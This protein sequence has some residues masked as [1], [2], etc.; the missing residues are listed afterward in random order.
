MYL[1]FDTET[2]GLPKDW[3]RPFTDVDNWPRMVQIAWQLHDDMG[4][5]LENVDYLIQPEGYDIPYDAE[6]VHGISTKLAAA[7]GVPVQQALDHLIQSLDKCRF[8]VGQNLKF[9][10]NIVGSELVRANISYEKLTKMPVLDT[11]TETT[12]EMLKIPGGRGGRFKL[13][14]LTELHKYLFDKPFAEAHNATADVE[15]TTRCFFE[16]LRRGTYGEK[17]LQAETGYL[18]RFREVNPDTIQP[19]GLKHQNLKEKS[20]ALQ[21]PVSEGPTKADIAE[22][23]GVL[24]DATFFH[25]HN[26][27]QYSVLQSTTEIPALVSKA[28]EFGMPAVAVTDLGNM[29]GA[30]H[31]I[32]AV[33]RHNSNEKK[34]VQEDPQYLPKPI[35]AMV[36][37]EL[38]LCKDRL[39]HKNKDNGYQIVFIAKNKA[40]YH[41]LARLSSSG[42]LEG[43]YYV[44]RIDRNVLLENKS[45]I[46]VTTGGIYGEVPQLIL[47]EGVGPAEEAFLWWKSQFGEDFYVELVRHGLPEEDRVNPVLLEFAQKHGVKVIAA[48]DAYYLEQKDANAHDALLCVKEGEKQSTPI[49]RGRGFRYGFP[50]DQFYFKS[51]DEMKR[52][53][54]DLPEAILNL[55]EVLDKVEEF[56]LAREVLL[57]NFEIPE[58]F[59]DPADEANGGKNGENAYLRHLT[60][61]GAKTRYPELTD[62][63]RERIDFELEIIAKTGYPG[64]FLIV[65]D[66]CHEARK[67][68]VSVG[69]GRG[70]AAGSVVAYCN[71]ITN[72]DPIKYD[73]LFERFLNPERV[74]L[75]DIDID[76]D[77][78]GRGK[79][80]KYVIDK[81]GENQ[82]AQIITYGKMAAKSAIRDTGRVMELPL[83]DTDHL[84]KMVPNNLS[85]AKLFSLTEKEL[86]DKVRSEEWDNALAL[87]NIIGGSSPESKVLQQ[88]LILEGSVRNTGIHACG[89]II[90][91]SDIRQLIPVAS[92]KDS[93]LWYTQFDNA[94][95]ESAGLLKMDFLGLRTL[96]IIKKAVEIVKDLTGETIDPEA[97]PLDDEKTYELFQRGETMGIFQYES[98][99]MRKSLRE[100]K[101]TVFEDLIAMNALYRPGPMDYIPS[102]IRRKHGEE[103]IHYD[104]PEME[105]ILRE[106]YGITVYQEQVMLLSQHLADFTKG[107]ADMLRKAMGKKLK[108]VLDTMKPKF[109]EQAH[110][111]GHPKEVLEKIWTDWEKFAAYAFNKSH[112]TCYAY[113]AFQTAYLKAHFPEAFYASVL[114]NN[115]KDIKTLGLYME[116]CKSVG[117]KV[118]VPSVNVSKL[119]FTVDKDKQIVFGLA[120]IKGV[121]EAAAK[122]II[123]EREANGPYEDV[124]DF[125]KRVDLRSVNKKNIENLVLSGGFDDFGIPRSA[126]FVEDN[127][128]RPFLDVLMKFGQALQSDQQNA[129]ASLFGEIEEVDIQYPTFPQV[130]EWDRMVLLNK[131]KEV[132]GLYISSHP[133]DDFTLEIGHFARHKIHMLN[134]NLNDLLPKMGEGDRQVSSQEFTFAGMIQGV[135]HRTSSRD[136][137]PFGIFHIMDHSGSYEFKLFGD[138]YVKY[139]NFLYE[140]SFVLFSIRVLS[141]YR[142]QD[143]SIGDPRIEFTRMEVLG[144]V[145]Q[146]SIKK[147]KLSLMLNRINEARVGNL[148]AALHEFPG[149]TPLEVEFREGKDR[150]SFSSGFKIAAER[151]LFMRLKEMESWLDWRLN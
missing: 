21:A 62:E 66:F 6:K 138:A 114:S 78:L 47:Q 69:P 94:V 93:E 3:N 125:I 137:K 144:E 96:S 130:P 10:V 27:S 17:A 148:H 102:F 113:V 140:A 128:G 53:F 14:T 13:P 116:A 124:F 135:Q 97:V 139:R 123:E 33:E 136:G 31:F 57:P 106:T 58:Q 75:P 15:A 101:P 143:G 90:T 120:G 109:I 35:R 49:G 55:Q 79:V 98:E 24:K 70:S 132:N 121:G 103:D 46:I 59:I 29:M 80:I 44:P 87:R 60:Y 36:G 145:L 122:N 68:G 99:G 50:N 26:H 95:V 4:Q 18:Q 42:Y 32:S 64:Y 67:M 115:L 43:F 100:L 7:E 16:L 150:V 146:K 91:P 28:A 8:I 40:G 111:K 20:K 81:Y 41:N 151:S 105:D 56:T 65:Q 134:R 126:F 129:Q 38:Y 1:I 84:S 30:F 141:G 39:N 72:I 23:I 51:P 89:V 48:N 63:I 85:L 73:L 147:V 110:A 118:R 25:I 131:E 19:Y 77:D 2:T 61:E 104:L 52:A 11:C 76:F 34:K 107:E 37:V 108:A 88:A 119:D 82:V 117:I 112:S 22:N 127:D 74:S 86:K 12:A 142:R 149:A 92:S 5:L 9:D 54:A 45:D 71:G 83:K 133:L